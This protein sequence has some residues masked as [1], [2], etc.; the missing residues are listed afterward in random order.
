MVLLSSRLDRVS[1]VDSRPEL[2]RKL[3]DSMSIL[4]SF[5]QLAR[6]PSTLISRDF[7]RIASALQSDRT[8]FA[9]AAYA[10]LSSCDSRNAR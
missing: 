2:G 10:L 9:R 4:K 1:I 8:D 7:L 6:R 3:S 5:G